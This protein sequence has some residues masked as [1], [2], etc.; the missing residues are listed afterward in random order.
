MSIALL[1]ASAL[2]AATLG[3][4]PGRRLLRSYPTADLAARRSAAIE[5]VLKIDPEGKLEEC[6]I[7][8]AVGHE[9]LASKTC[10]I[11]R[12]AR[13]EYTPATS[14][15]GI[16]AY[17]VIRTSS[18]FHLPGTRAGRA[19]GKHKFAPEVELRVEALPE[20]TSDP[21]DVTVVTMIGVDGRISACEFGPKE[22]ADLAEAA[23]LQLRSSEWDR[24]VSKAGAAVPYVREFKVRFTAGDPSSVPES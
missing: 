6:T 12:S 14:P 11:V 8:R 17:G 7:L 16:P 20:G 5:Y 3:D 23:C 2:A 18:S 15:D 4:D 19:I 1:G 24:I 9:E 10:A 22:R 13:F 21:L